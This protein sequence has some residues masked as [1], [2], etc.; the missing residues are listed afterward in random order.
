[1]GAPLPKSAEKPPQSKSVVYLMRL[2]QVN[3][4]LAVH[5][6]KQGKKV[7]NLSDD[8]KML[9]ICILEWQDSHFWQ[10]CRRELTGDM[11]VTSHLPYCQ[12]ARCFEI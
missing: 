11:R 7:M 2:S 10:F 3:S 12:T 8:L 4:V 9:R 5:W 1:L 6:Q